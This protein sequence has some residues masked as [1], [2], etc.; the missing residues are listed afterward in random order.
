MSTARVQWGTAPP[1][2]AQDIEGEVYF[3]VILLATNFKELFHIMFLCFIYKLAAS[4][5]FLDKLFIINLLKEF[6]EDSYPYRYP[7]NIDSN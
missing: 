5:Y 6:Y 2:I 7:M 1:V 4:M 3:R